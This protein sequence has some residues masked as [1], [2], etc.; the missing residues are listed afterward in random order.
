MNP[1]ILVVDDEPRMRTYLRT[2]LELDSYNVDM[3]ESGDAALKRIQEGS[4]PDLVLLDLVMP[5][6]DG[7]QTLAQLRQLEPSLGVIMLSCISEPRKVA[8]AVRLGARDYLAKPFKREELQAVVRQNLQLSEAAAPAGMQPGDI[9]E[10]SP[11]VCF[12][13]VS[14]AMRNLRQQAIAIANSEIPVL[15]LGESGTGKEVVAKLIHSKSPRAH[16]TFLNVNCA[17]IPSELLES[18]LFGYEAGAFTGANKAKPG[19]FELCNHGTILLDEIGE[20]SPSL[21]AKLLHV[22]QDQ[23]FSRLGG[24]TNIK[25]DVRIISATNIDMQEA[26]AAR[27]FREDVYYRLAG[28]TLRVPPL[29][30]RKEEIPHL[31]KYLMSRWANQYARPEAP[32]TRELVE[33][34]MNYSWP[35]NIRELENF[36][37]RYL[38]LGHAE[39]AISELA[40]DIEDQGRTP[41][42]GTPSRRDKRSLRSIK[43]EAEADAIRQ[44]LRETNW[45]RKEAAERLNISYKA[46]LYKLRQYNIRPPQAAA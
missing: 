8:Q 37:K 10:I 24:R 41:V 25:V 18:E 12:V 11:D 29:R 28:F 19:M 13:G 2:V 21:Q 46:L 9:I 6:L 30:Q 36:I 31:L 14:P 34:C 15:L 4:H 22:L 1:S 45:H 17:A 43:G 7:M 16:R 26:I 3:A 5:G 42:A 23:Q 27:K 44:A 20:M 38:I 39:L 35:G 32:L 33:A 40:Y